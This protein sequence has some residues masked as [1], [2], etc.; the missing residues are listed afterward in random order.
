MRAYKGVRL[1]AGSKAN[2]RNRSHLGACTRCGGRKGGLK[3]VFNP[4]PELLCQ[5]CRDAES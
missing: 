3:P 4:E 2:G 5:P 1:Q